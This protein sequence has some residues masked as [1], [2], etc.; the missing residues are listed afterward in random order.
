MY[1][2]LDQ[3][4]LFYFSPAKFATNGEIL[5]NIQ[6]VNQITFNSNIT[7]LGQLLYTYY[8]IPF[9]ISGFILLLAMISSI[10]LT[11]YHNVSVKRQDLFTQLDR[12]NT[13]SVYRWDK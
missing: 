9:I 6:W 11:L 5:A 7:L 12:S 1:Y 4:G 3:S 13:I 8:L 2:F 10:T